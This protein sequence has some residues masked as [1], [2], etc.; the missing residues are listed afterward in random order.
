MKKIIVVLAVLFTA[1]CAHKL[2]AQTQINQSG[3]SSFPYVITKPGSYI[4]TSNLTVPTVNTTAIFVE[5]SNVQVN[6]NGYTITGPNVCSASSCCI[7]VESFG[8]GIVGT[9]TNTIVENGFISGFEVG[10]SINAGLVHDLTI[11]GCDQGIN[12]WGATIK[13]N[14]VTNSGGWGIADFYGVVN[15]NTVMNNY[16]GIFAYDTSVANNSVTGSIEYGLYMGGGVASTNVL[17]NNNPDDYLYSNAVSTKT[18]A[19]TTGAC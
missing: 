18:N 6:L 4:L 12:G 13:Q 17:M 1:L 10:A 15:D 14:A 8:V 5:A 19:C 16:S 9:A 2:A 3:I 7:S 11:T